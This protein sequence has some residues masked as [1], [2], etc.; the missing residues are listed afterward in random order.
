[1][2]LIWVP[3]P[4]MDRIISLAREHGPG[5]EY[6]H[7]VAKLLDAADAPAANLRR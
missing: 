2:P 4:V 6:G 1:M 3:Q 5:T 7:M